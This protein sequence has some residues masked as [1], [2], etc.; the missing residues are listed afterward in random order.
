MQ[1]PQKIRLP[2]VEFY[3]TNVCNLACEGCNRF[4]NYRFRG[5][6]T[7][8][9]YKPIYTAWAEQVQIP[10]ISILGGEP[11]LN[12]DFMSWFSGIRELWPYAKLSTVTNA[13]RLNR[14]P[15]LYD[16]L[17][18]HQKNTTLHVGI[19]NKKN[20]KFVMDQIKNF[21]TS[22]IEFE[23][24]NDDPYYEFMWVRD[25][26]GVVIKVEY[27]WWF[28]QGSI[29]Q[30]L[31]TKRFSL[32]NSDVEKAHANCSMKTCHTFIHGKLYKCGVVG[33][34]PEFAE[35]YPFD[36]SDQDRQLMQGYSALTV[37]A[38]IESKKEF[39][40]DLPNAISQ[41]KFCPE[42]YNG[43]Q[44]FALEKRELKC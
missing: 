8:E 40:K 19:H 39:F 3:I 10:Q 22:P 42:S 28:H 34:L 23:F 1:L 7:W 6:Q 2:L 33:L 41:C 27:N 29:I 36:L 16:F 21:L 31:E 38:D 37:N 5:F 14:V 26:N 13:Y 32:H 24:N 17:K 12:P 44:I 11:L 30:D 4:N 18:Q 43:K 25:S 15:G 9:E 20:K 35:Q